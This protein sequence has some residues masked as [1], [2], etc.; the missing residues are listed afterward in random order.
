MEKNQEV[1]NQQE[2]QAEEKGEHQ[3]KEEIERIQLLLEEIQTR[4]IKL[5][6]HEKIHI[7]DKIEIIQQLLE[8]VAEIIEIKQDLKE[9]K[10]PQEKLI[11]LQIIEEALKDKI[12]MVLSL[13]QIKEE[14]NQEKRVH[15]EENSL[16][17][18]KEAQSNQEEAVKEKEITVAHKNKIEVMEEV[19]EEIKEEAKKEVKIK[20][21]HS[22]QNQEDHLNM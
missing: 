18:K 15:Q 11:R 5:Y 16:I 14:T 9:G 7:E 8:K 22:N 3:V 4:E 21:D 1:D 19:K 17:I 13:N 20:K 12:K 10:I 2:D 6:L